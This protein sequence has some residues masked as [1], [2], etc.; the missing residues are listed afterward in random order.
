[1]L[2]KQR[3]RGRL[4]ILPDAITL[5]KGKSPSFPNERSRSFADVGAAFAACKPEPD[6]PF[7]FMTA[8]FTYFPGAP[9]AAASVARSIGE[10][11]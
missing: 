10:T 5:Y 6:G 1:M 4:R 3:L 2:A 8:F 9:S 11:A 7:C